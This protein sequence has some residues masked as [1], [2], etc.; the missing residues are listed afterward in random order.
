MTVGQEREGR[1][2]GG[3]GVVDEGEDGDGV[4]EPLL[5]DEAVDRAGVLAILDIKLVHGVTVT[6]AGM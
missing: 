3:V 1:T 4:I 6:T 2:G 5:L